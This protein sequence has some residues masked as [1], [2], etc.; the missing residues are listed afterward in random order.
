MYLDNEWNDCSNFN[1]A[2]QYWNSTFQSFENHWNHSFD[3]I[4]PDSYKECFAFFHKKTLFIGL[5]LVGGRVQ[6]TSEWQKRLSWQVEWTKTLILQYTQANAVVILGHANPTVDHSAFFTPLQSFIA[7]RLRNRIPLLYMNGDAHE[8]HYQENF[9]SQRNFLRI[10]LTGGTV[11]PPLKA[12][13]N[14]SSQGIATQTCFLYDRRI[15]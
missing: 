6:S 5:N 13:V 12:M 9:Y 3:V 1:M 11:E 15:N 4:R 8:W 10:Q 7:N 14:A 2:K